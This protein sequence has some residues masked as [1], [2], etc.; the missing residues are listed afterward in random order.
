MKGHFI[1]DRRTEMIIGFV[2]VIVGGFLLWDAFDNRGKK[3]PFP[4]SG[5]AF[6]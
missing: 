6:W 5:L 4:L 2:V 1:A 3:L